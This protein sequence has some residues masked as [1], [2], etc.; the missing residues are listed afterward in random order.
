MGAGLKAML[1]ADLKPGAQLVLELL[2]VETAIARADLVLTGE[3]RLDYQTAFG[4][5]PGAVAALAARHAV[6]C[7][8]IAGMLDDSAFRLHDRGFTAVFN[9]C[10][11]PIALNDA[12]EHAAKYLA[13]VTE[14][15]MRCLQ[16]SRRN[17]AA[18]PA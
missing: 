17:G 8:A 15:V 13:L 16:L 12:M 1:G 10:P 9:L 3:G 5:A 14:Q 7:I 18:D 2:Q 6:P 11:G 4:K